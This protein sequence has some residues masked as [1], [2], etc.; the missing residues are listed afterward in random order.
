MP[1]RLPPI[2]VAAWAVV[3]CAADDARH[4]S[5]P[6]AFRV[7][8]TDGDRGGPEAEARLEFSTEGVAFTLE[9]SAVQ[10]PAGWS[11]W[12]ALRSEPG[13]IVSVRAP[14]AIRGNVPLAG[15]AVA[16]AEV[17]VAKGYGDTYIWA[18]DIGFVPGP[19]VGSQCGDG[20][21]NDGDGRTDFGDDPGCAWS[22]DDSETPGS[23]AVGVSEPLHFANPRVSDVQGRSFTSPLEGRAVTIDAGTLVVTR[24]STSGLYVTDISED[25]DYTSLFAYNYNTPHRVRVCDRL[26]AVGGIVSEF[27]GLT[28]LVFPSWT[29]DPS[30]RRAAPLPAGPDECPVPEPVELDAVTLRNPRAM[31]SLESALVAVVGGTITRNFVDCDY[32]RNRSIDWDRLDER[33]CADT[34]D[35]D[36]DC[37]ERSQFRRYG[38][39]GVVLPGATPAGR[40]KVFVVTREAIPEEEFDPSVEDHRG[41]TVALV[42]GTLQHIEFLGVP[43]IVEIRCRDDLVLEGAALPMWRACV[44][45]VDDDEGYAR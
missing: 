14:G 39:F 36:P 22:N 19:V 28:E 8:V 1:D 45:P 6:A 23:F 21:D 4:V 29:L 12:V 25:R 38:Q 30:V 3:A 40:A 20:I 15:E 42:R 34:C 35:A 17:S 11:G 24:V 10:P 7:R 33:E 18:A 5:G 13:E 31:E 27:Y 26:V 32:N 9:I 41:R 43:W 16:T 37:T 44:P 2:V